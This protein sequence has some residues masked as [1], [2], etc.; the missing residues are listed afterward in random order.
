[1]KNPAIYNVHA[2]SGSIRESGVISFDDRPDL[3]DHKEL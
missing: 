1:M 3:L 2:A